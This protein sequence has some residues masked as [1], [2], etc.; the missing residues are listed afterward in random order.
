MFTLRCTRKLLKFLDV[1]PVEE[2]EPPTGALGDWYANLI[3]TCAGDLI[4]FV[5]ERSLITVAVPAWEAEHLIPLFRL[6]VKNLFTGMG[7]ARGVIERELGHLAPV[8]FAKTASRSILGCMNDM[9][10]HY[11]IRAEEAQA[12]GDLRLSP[13]ELRLS[14]MPFSP[15]DYRF[16][17]DVA[18]ELLMECYGG[19]SSATYP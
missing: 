6:R 17:T 10:W 2:P 3:P 16:P 9:A 4:I 15:L 19:E 7:L 5:N 14:Q 1:E 11:Q 12:K 8:Q 13:V 18:E